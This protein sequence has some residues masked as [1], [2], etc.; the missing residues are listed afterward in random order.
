MQPHT[1]PL[2]LCGHE[3]RTTR[4]PCLSFHVCGCSAYRPQPD[5]TDEQ[6]AERRRIL[7]AAV[8]ACPHNLR[9]LPPASEE[10]TA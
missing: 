7:L 3:H 9:R 2:C 10:A 5:D 1:Q 8:D 4:G 6:I